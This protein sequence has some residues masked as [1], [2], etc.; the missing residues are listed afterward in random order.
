MGD[1][2]T[3]FVS[4]LSASGKSIHTVNAYKLDIVCFFRYMDN[5]RKDIS[6]ISYTDLL[7]WMEYMEKNGLSAATRSRKISAI[8][9]F[10]RYLEKIEYISKNPANNLEKP[11]LTKKAPKVISAD[12]AKE[13]LL[14][15]YWSDRKDNVKFRDYAI[16]ATF[17]FTG[18]RRE[19]LSNIKLS[20]IDEG[21]KTILIHGKGDKER[22]VYVND[23]LYPIIQEYIKEHRSALKCAAECEYLF[24]SIRGKKLSLNTI[25]GIV[26]KVME[27]VGIKEKGISAHI[28]RKRFATT[29]FDNTRDIA[30][31]S[32]LLGH[33]S[34]TVTMR[35]VTI[36]EN[37]LRN[38]TS[39]VYF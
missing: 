39:T 9:T 34:P 11:K 30:T 24:L 13:L 18:I 26:N 38:V 36:D 27:S 35:Y 29:A 10:F 19:E 12:N 7:V 15:S 28:L 21:S 17:L 33:S 25:D 4:Y 22:R 20:D 23:S 37:I 5:K 6:E 2:I 32:K 31:V 8:K 1:I 3:G 16:I 14:H